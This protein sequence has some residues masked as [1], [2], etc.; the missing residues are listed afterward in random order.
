MTKHITNASHRLPSLTLASVLC[1]L[2]AATTSNAQANPSPANSVEDDI[3]EVVD[4]PLA[5]ELAKKAGLTENEVRETVAVA[6]D[7]GMGAGTLSEVLVAE[8][9]AIK[10]R[11]KKKGLPG[12]VMDR[13]LTGVRGVDLKG[14]VKTR[15]ERTPKDP[16]QDQELRKKL[17]ALKKKRQ[18]E[19]KEKRLAIKQERKSGKKLKLRGR[20]AHER[21]ARGKRKG[22]KHLDAAEHHGTPSPGDAPAPAAGNSGRAKTHG[23]GAPQAGPPERPGKGKGKSQNKG[24]NRRKPGGSPKNHSAGKARKKG[25]KKRSAH[26]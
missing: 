12:W 15:P 7:G 1:T 4:L 16:S 8:A 9:D 17:K 2:L 24:S 25:K 3:L 19:L 22:P 5:A 14:Q 11:G 20:D 13:W 21:F 10:I 18:Q 26:R 23:A 6:R